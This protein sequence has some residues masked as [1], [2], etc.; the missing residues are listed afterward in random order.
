MAN[1]LII[2]FSSAGEKIALLQD[3]KLVELHQEDFSSKFSVGD[4]YLGVVKKFKQE[5]NAAFIDV[6]HQRD[7]FLHYQDMGPNIRSLNK[8][9]RMALQ[10]GLKS[11]DL[12][13]FK[14]EKETLKTGRITEQ[15]K[16][17]QKILVQVA[18]EPISSKGPKLNMELSIPGKYF[19][20]VPFIQSVTVSKKIES[21]EERNRLKNL[22]ISLK[23]PNYGLICRTAAEGKT[24]QDLHKDLLEIQSKWD[25]AIKNLKNAR[26]GDLV[27]G[28]NRRSQLVL[29]DLLSQ[30][31]S[32]IVTNDK[33]FYEE[34]KQY[35]Q[36]LS[37]ELVK[38]LKLYKGKEPIF[39][40]FGIDKQIK[41]LF[42]KSVALQGGPYL[43]IEHTE[44]LHVIDVNSGNKQKR[45]DTT[46]EYSL[47]V[48]IEAAR[49]IARQL[50]LR[51]MGGIIVIDFIDLRNPQHK[52]KLLEEL[53]NAM[54][55]DRAKHTIL[56]MSKFGLVQITRQRVRPETNITTTEVCPMCHGEG[57]IEAS[58]LIT[59]EIEHKLVEIVKSSQHKQL[60]LTTHPFLEAYFKKGF[61]N[62][63]WK[64]W[65]KYKT[66]VKISADPNYHYGEYHFFDE[67]EEEIVL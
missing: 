37:P 61:F 56:P 22:A 12:T 34:L 59:D 21:S 26:I 20:M 33:G 57:K 11:G 24:A 1:E 60:E 36:N 23:S 4:L 52:R 6:G 55:N 27:L 8:L 66:R 49:E 5:L 13:N 42:G 9:T 46:A 53:K 2:D 32:A 63:P 45:G 48:N 54:S 14:L 18:K 15:L 25:Q 3:R 41:M 31:F 29:R 50:R 47:N 30:E 51:D 19:I 28:E 64:W 43:I 35:L 17:G 39:S 67:N 40:Q 62:K 7:A 65:M 38:V 16:K 58:I 10:G 44:A